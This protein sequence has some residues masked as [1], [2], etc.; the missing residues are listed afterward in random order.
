M[1]QEA[2]YVRWIHLQHTRA[3]SC[4]SSWKMRQLYVYV[5]NESTHSNID[6][7]PGCLKNCNPRMYTNDINLTT[8]GLSH[9]Q[10]Q[11]P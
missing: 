7:L 2:I 11:E 9:R 8:A 4:R 10:I 5:A 3:Y 6:K 1:L